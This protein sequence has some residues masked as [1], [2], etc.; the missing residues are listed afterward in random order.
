MGVPGQHVQAMG[1]GSVNA[2]MLENLG[3][4]EDVR[5]IRI[6]SSL[7]GEGGGDPGADSR[8]PGDAGSRALPDT[9]R[10]RGDV[11]HLFSFIRLDV[12]L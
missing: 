7:S 6:C 2:V 5:W 10:Q 8:V 9:P 4:A 12:T 3:V 1:N 11:V